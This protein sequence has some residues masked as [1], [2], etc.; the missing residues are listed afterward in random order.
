M[1]GS[2][3]CV[4]ELFHIIWFWEGYAVSWS[5]LHHSLSLKAC[6]CR[7]L[8]PRNSKEQSQ[9]QYNGLILDAMYLETVRNDL[10]TVSMML[11]MIRNKWL[12]SVSV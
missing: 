10:G 2:H 9:S 12:T 3:V 11:L 5:V 7:N 1:R 6:L 4:P 8:Y